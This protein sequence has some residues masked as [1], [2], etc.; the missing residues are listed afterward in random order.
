[1]T[2]LPPWAE[3]P[4]S[5]TLTEAQYDGLQVGESIKIDRMLR[6]KEMAKRMGGI[7]PL[8][9][10]LEKRLN[11]GGTRPKRNMHGP[12]PSAP[13]N[14]REIEEKWKGKARA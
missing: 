11:L 14:V 7:L 12:N 4:G 1:M 5:L 8:E 2:S 10:T 3:D 6:V 9:V 13:W